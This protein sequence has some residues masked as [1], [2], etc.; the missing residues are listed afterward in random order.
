MNGVSTASPNREAGFTLIET[1]M[2]TAIGALVLGAVVAM[3]YQFNSLTTL[4]Q[5]S[6]T[7]NHQI[8]SAAAALNRDV[9]SAASGTVEAHRLTLQIPWYEFGK[10]ITS[11]DTITYTH[12]TD[13]HVLTRD[14]GSGGLIVARHVDSVDFGP[15][16]SISTTLQ[17]TITVTIPIRVRRQTATLEFHRRP[18][19]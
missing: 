14:E 10:M 11:T 2:A 19:D 16:G 7:L 18:I 6:L 5:D 13:D 4:Y 1:M 3:L 12:V 15:S 9:V 8:Q 17:V